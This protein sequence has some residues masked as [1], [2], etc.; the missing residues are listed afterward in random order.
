MIEFDYWNSFLVPV[1]TL[2]VVV[3]V[4]LELEELELVAV[5]VVPPLVVVDPPVLPPL[6]DVGVMMIGE[7]PLA[8]TTPFL[9]I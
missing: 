6:V 7:Y 3:V 5:V 2:L 1:S 4:E 8:V 9:M